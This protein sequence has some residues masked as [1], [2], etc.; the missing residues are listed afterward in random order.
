ME[1]TQADPTVTGPGVVEVIYRVRCGHCGAVCGKAYHLP[2]LDSLVPQMGLPPGWSSVNTIPFCEKHEITL[3]D[4][5]E[6]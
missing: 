1:W 6:A 4:R 5:Q 3:K 2:N